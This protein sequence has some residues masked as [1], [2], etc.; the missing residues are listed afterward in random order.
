MADSPPRPSVRI[1]AVGDIHCPKVGHGAF[2]ALF[3]AMTASADVALLC[4]DLTDYG[5][6]EEARVLARELTTW[7]K[8]PVVAVLGN[9]DYEAGQ[10]KE[11]AQVLTD[12]GVSVLDGDAIEIAGIG[13]A[14]VKGFAG[15]FGRHA[16]GPSGETMISGA[17]RTRVWIRAGR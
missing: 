11:I 6:A 4:G 1:A 16:L 13:F 2:Q 9:H 15:G 14:G 7:V 5:L 17:T 3:S 8:I 10:Q 12:A